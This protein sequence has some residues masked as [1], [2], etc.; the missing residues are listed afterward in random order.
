MVLRITL[1]NET[2]EMSI[3]NLYC[4]NSCNIGCL[5]AF[6]YLFISWP[7]DIKMSNI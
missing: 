3:H 2:S 1:K 4:I 5:H 7:N 6:V